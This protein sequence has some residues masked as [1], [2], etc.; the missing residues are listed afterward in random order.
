MQDIL[1]H[2]SRGHISALRYVMLEFPGSG[3]DLCD[4]L[5]QDEILSVNNHD[6]TH[7]TLKQVQG[8]ID[9]SVK[10]GQ[11]ELKVRRRPD[12]GR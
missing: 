9:H 5:A 10:R 12:E 8:I 6:T 11:I 7:M 2:I 1:L 3:A 4:L